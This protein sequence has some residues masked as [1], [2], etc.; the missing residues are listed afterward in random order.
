[1]DIHA[2]DLPDPK[3]RVEAVEKLK[4]GF[5]AIQKN[6]FAEAVQIFEKLVESNPKMTDVWQM[7]GQAYLRLGRDDQ[8]LAALQQAARVSPGSPQVLFA[9]SEYYLE[10]GQFRK[11]REHAELA[12]D[13]GAANAH[14]NLAKI[15]VTEGDLAAAE[16]EAEA[17]LKENRH[18][19]IP[20]LILGR[21]K[22]DRGDLLGALRELETALDLSR[23]Q[24]REALYNLNFL[25]GDILARLGREKEAEEAFR[26]EMKLFP[27]ATP[28]QTGLALLYASQ[29]REAKARRALETLVAVRTPEAFTAAIR[30]YEILGDLDTAGRLRAQRRLI[31][32]AARDRRE[33]SG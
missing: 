25:R 29:G 22:R 20:H 31:F 9:L 26:E 4:Q 13:A 14:L 12:R 27:S 6:Q 2:K 33:A 28:P 21:V 10:T 7:L 16:S 15:A 17:A 24:G 8:A 32:P 23:K 18:A 30:A 3:D 19:R 11:A 1:V 5:G